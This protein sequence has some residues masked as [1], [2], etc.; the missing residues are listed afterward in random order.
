MLGT[1]IHQLSPATKTFLLLCLFQTAACSNPQVTPSPITTSSAPIASTSTVATAQTPRFDPYDAAFFGDEEFFSPK[2]KARPGEW[3]HRFPST[4][5]IFDEYVQRRPVSRTAQ[6]NTIV[7]QPLGRFSD[8]DRQMLNKLREFMDAF[9]GVTTVLA[10]DSPLPDHGLRTRNEGGKVWRQIHTEVLLNEVLAPNLPSNAVCYL[11]VTMT[12]LYPE[13]GWNYVFGQAT[14]DK[15]VGVYSLIRYMPSFWGKPDTPAAR[16]LA[17]LRSFKVMSHET[18]HM[19]SMEHCV[20]F[21][22]NMNGSNSLEEMDQQPAELCPACLK[23]LQWNLSFDIRARYG[24]LR[25]IYRREGLEDQ[26]SWIDRRLNKI[27]PVTNPPLSA[28]HP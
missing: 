12:D 11:G 4:G 22:C 2:H 23:M 20:R 19:F 1:L 8:S 26:A 17:L 15:R 14:L 9:F 5:I 10:P 28:P 24:H 3:L 7:I 21:E 25:D 16:K 27:E 18:G 6:R 13:P